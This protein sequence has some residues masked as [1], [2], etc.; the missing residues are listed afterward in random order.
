MLIAGGFWAVI[1]TH[2]AQARHWALVW[3]HF[4]HVVVDKGVPKQVVW[5]AQHV[6]D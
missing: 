6:T 4:K 2:P 5:R 1:L 3:P